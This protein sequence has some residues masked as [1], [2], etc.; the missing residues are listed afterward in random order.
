[1]R[2]IRL[3]DV[4]LVVIGVFATF[5]TPLLRVCTMS[6]EVSARVGKYRYFSASVVYLVAI[7]NLSFLGVCAGYLGHPF[8]KRDKILGGD[9][10]S[11][12][13]SV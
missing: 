1:M 13:K 7:V 8:R 11:V 2:I 12:R 10:H 9:R 5:F 4:G 3:G 6:P